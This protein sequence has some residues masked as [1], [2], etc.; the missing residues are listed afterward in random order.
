MISLVLLQW[1]S[2]QRDG[3]NIVCNE[4]Q[5]SELYP[6]TINREELG[7][8]YL[9]QE[10]LDN[11]LLTALYNGEN[12]GYHG[13]SVHPAFSQTNSIVDENITTSSVLNTF[14]GLIF[15]PG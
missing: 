9:V 14:C 8:V 4:A 12:V 7:L 5:S 1:K 2:L 13:D 10:N 15:V 11:P 6:S 3:E